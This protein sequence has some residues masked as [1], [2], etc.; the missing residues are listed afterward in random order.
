MTERY[1]PEKPDVRIE[2]IDQRLIRMHAP[3]NEESLVAGRIFEA[4]RRHLSR[5]EVRDQ[6]ALRLVDEDGPSMLPAR[7][8]SAWPIMASLAAVVVLS[9]TIAML[10]SVQAQR[11]NEQ[12]P[13]VTDVG[14][15]TELAPIDEQFESE[16]NVA[17]STL[18]SDITASV[19]SLVS[20]GDEW[21]YGSLASDLQTA[22]SSLW[23][24]LDSF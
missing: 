7:A 5:A 24:D 4:S 3:G 6:P 1:I 8:W 23:E 2:Q 13:L 19:D 12:Q 21:A 20:Q 16:F 11:N 18:M 9:I 15:N 14:E 22:T 17:T 10:F